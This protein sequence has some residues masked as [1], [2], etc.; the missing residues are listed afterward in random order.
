MDSID[1]LKLMIRQYPGGLP[2]LAL[3]IG[4]NEET[5]RKELSG[6]AKFKLGHRDCM[7]ISDL[8]TEAQSGDCYA[9]VNSI[10]VGAGRL[11]ELPVRDMA[12]RK[13]LRT[14]ALDMLKE[15]SDT[16][17]AINVGLADDNISANDRKE[18]KRE[19][20]EMVGKAQAVLR[21]VDEMHEAG[22]PALRSAS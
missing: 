18:I 20:M 5:L 15:C 10:A 22:K 4:K 2:V 1:A 14:S 19:A 12:E 13:C 7:A 9:F 8:C 17:T 21:L 11:I 6:D 16:L 3:R